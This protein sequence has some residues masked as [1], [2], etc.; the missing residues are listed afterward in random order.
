MA[1]GALLLTGWGPFPIKTYR[2][3]IGSLP[4]PYHTSAYSPTKIAGKQNT[5]AVAEQWAA[6]D[7]LVADEIIIQ[8][9]FRAIKA[10]VQEDYISNVHPFPFH[11]NSW[12]HLP[13]HDVS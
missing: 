6:S 9:L 4:V 1:K 7:P 13:N 10:V 11:L 8:H 2:K 12:L 3:S 5:E